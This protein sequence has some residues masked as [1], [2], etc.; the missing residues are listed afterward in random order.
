MYVGLYCPDPKPAGCDKG[1]QR[2]LGRES[3]RAAVG[4]DFRVSPGVA[5]CE[6]VV[7]NIFLSILL[8]QL[9]HMLYQDSTIVVKFFAIFSD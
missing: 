2:I 5:L 7:H 3:K 1:R 4:Y 8:Q 6:K 9:Y